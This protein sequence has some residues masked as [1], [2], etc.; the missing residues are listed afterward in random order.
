MS[1]NTA[2]AVLDI[3]PVSKNEVT[4]TPTVQLYKKREAKG[5]PY[6]SIEPTEETFDDYVKF[7]GKKAIVE[8]LQMNARQNGQ[9][10]LD[11]V[12]ALKATPDDEYAG[13]S[14]REVQDPETKKTAE[15]LFYNPETD[16]DY[17]KWYEYLL[18][19]V[20]RQAGVTK[21]GLYYGVDNDLNFSEEEKSTIKKFF[22][23]ILFRD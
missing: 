23:R 1:D 2:Q 19:G 5:Q 11:A 21:A 6:L 9:E 14:H 4:L 15:Q 16:V 10:A 7:V 12:L 3:R 22:D 20:S 17:D 13:W 18:S 8:M